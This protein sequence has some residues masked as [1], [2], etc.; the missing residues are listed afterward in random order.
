MTPAPF[1]RLT[2][3]TAACA[4]VIAGGLTGCSSDEADTASD[5]ASTASSSASSSAEQDEDTSYG[6]TEADG[7]DKAE[8]ADTMD[9]PELVDALKKGGHVVFFRHA[10]TAKDYADQADPN[11]KLDDCST[12]RQLNDVGKRQAKEIGEAFKK[13]DIPVGDVITSQYC[14][15]WETADLAF[16]RHEENPALNFEPAEEY[17]DEQVERMKN[18]LTPLLSA[19]PADGENTVLVGHDDVFEAATGIYPEPQGIAYVVKPTGN[20]FELVA[21]VKAE[22]WGTLAG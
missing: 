9:G 1:R 13:Y 10:Q 21:N 22:E 11:M 5:A 15:A 19:E 12:Q 8:F 2:V 20:G 17:T 16:G 7:T 4:I 14:R 6:S 3:A 18:N